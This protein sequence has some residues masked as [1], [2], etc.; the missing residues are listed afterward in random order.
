MGSGVRTAGDD[1][2]VTAGRLTRD[3]MDIGMIEF[4]VSQLADF[5]KA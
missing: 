3:G 1:P 4:G 2:T 5:E